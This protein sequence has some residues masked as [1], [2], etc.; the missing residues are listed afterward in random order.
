MVSLLGSFTVTILSF[1][2]PP[3]LHLILVVK[4]QIKEE[5]RYQD[6]GSVD[7]STTGRLFGIS[8]SNTIG[9]YVDGPLGSENRQKPQ[10]GMDTLSG[11]I[12]NLGG[13]KLRSLQWQYVGDVILTILGCAVCIFTT[14]LT[15]DEAS[16]KF[17]AL[18]HC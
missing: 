5:K 11:I 3:V 15:A 1:V 4:P 6:V 16:R 8:D 12:T 10:S 7:E 2:L 13:R 14:V 17:S 18:C 9:S